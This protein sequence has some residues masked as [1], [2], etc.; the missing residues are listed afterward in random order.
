MHKQGREH[1]I[2]RIL[3]LGVLSEQVRWV[4]AHSTP[5]GN[6][7][8]EMIP[9]ARTMTHQWR[10]KRRPSGESRLTN[11]RMSPSALATIR[12]LGLSA[13]AAAL[14]AIPLRAQN[15]KNVLI[16]HDGNANYP[17]NIIYSRVLHKLI[18]SET[19]YQVFEDYVDQIR[20]DTSEDHLA[21]LLAKKYAG[22]KMDLVVTEGQFALTFFLHRGAT[23][24]PGAAEVFDFVRHSELP[25]QLPSNMTGIAFTMDFGATVDLALRLMP[26]T[27]RVFYIGEIRPDV[28]SWRGFAERDF[29]RFAGRVEFTYLDHLSLSQLLKEVSELPPH[30]IILY[31]GMYKDASGQ[32]FAPARICPLISSAS[33]AP[34]YGVSSTYLDC[35]I[36]GG[37]VVD[38]D[39]LADQSVKLALH[40]LE[41]GTAT[42]VPVEQGAAPKVI[43]DWRQLRRWGV[44]ASRLPPGTVIEFRTPSVW[45]RY[46]RQIVAVL[47][48]I[49]ALLGVI[50]ALLV[51]RRKRKTADSTV[52]ELSG[53]LISAGEEERRRV[54]RELHDDV[55]Q[56]LSLVAS[57]LSALERGLPISDGAARHATREQIQQLTEIITAV[58]QLSHQ[59]HSSK[60]ELLGLSVALRDL[61]E[62]LSAQHGLPVKLEVDADRLRL[63]RDRALCFYRVAQEALSNAIR[64]AGASHVEVKI[65][66]ADAKLKMTVRDDGAG[67]DPA[68][69]ATGL[70]LATMRERLRLLGGQLLVR[71]R[72]GAGTE[73]TAETKL[74]HQS[75][76]STA[77]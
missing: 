15:A 64:H 9:I 6:T 24:W 26:D 74:D 2:C 55:L 60:L 25:A 43:V 28:E 68:S 8:R 41:R 22:K 50:A 77:A 42:G 56:R 51:E 30:S 32:T 10:S 75:Q 57:D 52:Q 33:N 14:F 34:V 11:R 21:T 5:T 59:L 62:H 12:R 27:R 76:E 70:G 16:I 46:H 23:L 54:A 29:V 3:A 53:R 17:A 20:L 37:A 66:Q 61:C 73:V 65:T 63:S 40:V 1:S 35:G 71:S 39:A 36:V 69:P 38:F 67:F 31:A 45:E 47:L 58:R 44:E 19:K 49:A 72:P 18:A 48:A 13:T 4:A 7:T